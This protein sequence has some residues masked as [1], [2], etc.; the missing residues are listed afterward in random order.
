LFNSRLRLGLA[1]AS[2]RDN[3]DSVNNAG[4]VSQEGEQN[5]EPKLTSKADLEKNPKG[6]KEN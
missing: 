2:R 6:R 1:L 3:P 4:N 5:I